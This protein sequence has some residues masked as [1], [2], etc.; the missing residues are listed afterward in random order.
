MVSKSGPFKA[1]GSCSHRLDAL[2]RAAAAHSGAVA[3]RGATGAVRLA[4]CAAHDLGGGGAL[5]EACGQGG[6]GTITL[7]VLLG[8]QSAHQNRGDAHLGDRAL[9]GSSHLQQEQGR[10]AGWQLEEWRASRGGCALRCARCGRPLAPCQK[11]SPHQGPGQ[12]PSPPP[13]APCPM[14]SQV[15]L[16][17][18][19][20]Y[21]CKSMHTLAW[22]SAGGAWSRKK[23]SATASAAAW[24]TAATSG[25][26]VRQ[27]P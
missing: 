19:R 21:E 18:D 10:G 26:M 20:L 6:L 7:Q 9:E 22:A 27:Y 24:S 15:S 16:Q 5:G 23:T 25:S 2:A 17:L 13:P 14:L 3:Q 4:V 11:T 8:A 12:P 1:L